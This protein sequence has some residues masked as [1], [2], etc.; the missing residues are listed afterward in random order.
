MI[1]V[2]CRLV[3]VIAACG[4]IAGLPVNA[5]DRD[6][7]ASV[8]RGR[9]AITGRGFLEPAWSD[10]AYREASRSWKSEDR[11]PE[12][13]DAAF[14]LRYGLHP[15][16]FPNDGLPMGLRKGVKKDGTKT[17][18]QVDCL[19]CH[20]GSIGGTSYVGLGNS[21]LD[22]KAMFDDLNRA[23]GRPAPFSYFTVNSARGTVN[24]GMFSAVLLSLRNSDLSMRRFPLALKAT[25]PEL[26]TPPWWNLAKKSTMYYDGRTDARSARSLMQFLLG[27]KSLTELKE[28]EPTFEDIQAYLRSLKPPRYPFPIDEPLADRGRVVFEKNCSKCHGTYGANPTY[29]NEIIPLD[30][31]GT[32]P[33]RARGLSKE[34]VAHYNTTWLGEEL[35]SDLEMIGYQAP[36]LDGVWA[37]APYLHNGS[38]PTVR[39]L[40]NSKERPRKFLRPPS[41]DLEHYDS[42]QLGWKS[43]EISAPLPET[44]TPF[45]SRFLYDTS[46]FGLGN[47][48]HTFGDRLSED[49]RTAVIEYLKTL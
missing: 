41:T 31:I 25:L 18:I 13:H 19:S 45:R 5:A 24:A 22:M 2:P 43:E 47:G 9:A 21:T 14:R 20:G 38:V 30:V 42:K 28:L 12:D 39:A 3:G 17:G 15:A 34:L 27:E 23:E 6:D 1:P 10:S 11:F 7:P 46:R 49:E 26:D 40:L 8:E 4:L 36:P 29:P 37:T 32:D 44:T 35:P 16:P 33:E 48:G